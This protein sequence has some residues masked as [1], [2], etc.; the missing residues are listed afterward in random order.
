LQRCQRLLTPRELSLVMLKFVK[1]LL[2][3][4]M[5]GSLCGLSNPI[6]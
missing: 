2:P 5:L 4:E 1:R 3:V 6:T